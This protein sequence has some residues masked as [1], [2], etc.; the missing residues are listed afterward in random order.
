MALDSLEK[1]G[2][3]QGPFGS[4]IREKYGIDNSDPNEIFSDRGLAALRLALTEYREAGA[5]FGGAPTFRLTDH[6]AGDSDERWEYDPTSGL[7]LTPITRARNETAVQIARDVYGDQLVGLIA[8][9]S[10]TSGKHD[11]RWATLGENKVDW[12][13]QR[14]R[15]QIEVLCNAGISVIWGEAFRYRD[16]AIAIARLAKELGVEALVICF[17]ANDNGVPDPTNGGSYTFM[18]MKRDLQAEAGS[19]I[20]VFVGANCTGIKNIRKVW[21]RGDLVDVAYPNSLNFGDHEKLEFAD[22]VETH[23]RTPTQNARI[24]R[25]VADHATPLPTFVSFWREAFREHGVLIAGGCCGTGPEHTWV[26][27]QAF[28]EA[29]RIP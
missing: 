15:P 5:T 4:L 12:A 25:M 9:L 20:E 6:R 29:K 27:R 22:L 8:P 2:V 11:A 13:M 19:G 16:E 10:D 1:G 3:P 28:N 24:S 17:E 23:H 21:E 14:Q 18:D 7:H 26:A